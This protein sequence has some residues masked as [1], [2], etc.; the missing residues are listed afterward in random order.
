MLVPQ[1]SLLFL[2][3]WGVAYGS[4]YQQRGPFLV[5]VEEVNPNSDTR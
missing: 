5:P 1:L 4:S 2:K 3:I